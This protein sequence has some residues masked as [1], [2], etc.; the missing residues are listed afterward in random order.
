M[1]GAPYRIPF[2]GV[3]LAA[4]ATLLFELALIRILSF[5]IWYHFGHVV[6]SMAFLG[7]G[8]AERLSSRSRC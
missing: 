4:F 1:G 3:F 5:P 8:F 7:F 2:S 6:I